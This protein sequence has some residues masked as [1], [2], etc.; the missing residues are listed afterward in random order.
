MYISRAHVSKAQH[1]CE[2]LPIRNTPFVCLCQPVF[3]SC[4]SRIFTAIPI[5]ALACRYSAPPPPPPP[6]SPTTPRVSFS[7]RRP[8]AVSPLSRTIAT[9]LFWFSTGFSFK[10]DSD[11]L[12]YFGLIISVP[13]TILPHAP[14]PGNRFTLLCSHDKRRNIT[15]VNYAFNRARPT[16]LYLHSC[17]WFLV[18][19]CATYCI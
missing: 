6:P 2:L 19:P 14:F 12:W 3:S 9:L 4:H 11:M 10:T 18:N 13:I 1:M 17:D 5:F 8:T 16:V 7:V 15:F